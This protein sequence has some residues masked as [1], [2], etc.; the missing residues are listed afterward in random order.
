MTPPQRED[1]VLAMYPFARGVAFAVF[2][3]PLALTDWGIKW[4]RA[5]DKTAASITIAQALIEH[6]Q[7]DAIVLEDENRNTRR[8]KRFV[9]FNQ[10]VENY[11][12]GQVI[13]VRQYDRKAVRLCFERVGARTRHEIAQVISARVEEFRSILPPTR[14]LWMPPDHRLN[15]FNAASLALTFYCRDDGK[16]DVDFDATA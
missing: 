6:H 10:R 13:D 5:K 2:R 12:Q 16:P 3:G 15:I 4:I 14:K 11:A 8:S 7:P 9:R 1:K